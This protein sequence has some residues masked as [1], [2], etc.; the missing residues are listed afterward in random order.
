MEHFKFNKHIKIYL[1]AETY[2]LLIEHLPYQN[3]HH[4]PSLIY[5]H[6]TFTI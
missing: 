2:S 4:M 1:E 3:T 6:V 5:I